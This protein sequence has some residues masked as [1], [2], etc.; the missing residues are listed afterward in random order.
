MK[1]LFPSK[2]AVFTLDEAS[3]RRRKVSTDFIVKIGYD[4]I[5]PED[6]VLLRQILNLT[7][8]SVNAVYQLARKY[9]DKKWLDSFFNL[10]EEESKV[11]CEEL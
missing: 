1:Q 10:E 3:S 4:E 7:E 11:V 6:V 9:G 5:E 2:V 8:A